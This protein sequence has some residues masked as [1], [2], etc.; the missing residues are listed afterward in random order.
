ML[1][2]QNRVLSHLF[3]CHYLYA[4]LSMNLCNYLSRSPDSLGT[5]CV[6]TNGST[7]SK[8]SMDLCNYLSRSPDSLGTVCVETNGST[9]SK[10]GII[11]ITVI[12]RIKMP[13]INNFCLSSK[14][15][16]VKLY[17]YDP[18]TIIK[19]PIYC[20]VNTITW[21][22]QNTHYDLRHESNS[23]NFSSTWVLK[24]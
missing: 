3:I 19:F 13:K 4:K 2:E 21:I 5:V 16:H 23:K 8:L 17:I 20:I 1:K 10:R 22:H 12:K 7:T 11:I 15:I 24:V 14:V 6:E 18:L 9:T